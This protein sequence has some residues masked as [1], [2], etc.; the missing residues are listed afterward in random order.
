MMC[1]PLFNYKHLHATG[2][3]GGPI[4]LSY[5]LPIINC[6]LLLAGAIAVSMQIYGNSPLPV[7]LSDV[8]CSAEQNTLLE[9]AASSSACLPQA[10]GAGVVCQASFTRSANCS[11]GDIRLMNGS[12]VLEGRVEICINN[13]WG[14]VC[15]R[16][17]SE[18]E[19][20][21]ICGQVAGRF[22]GIVHSNED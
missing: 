10:A 3:G 9:C 13:A 6:V 7:V 12:T 18:D 20:N 21:V 2:R 4:Y 17:F 8:A 11:D 19:A 16:T 5:P 22:N 14:T 1:P 15:D